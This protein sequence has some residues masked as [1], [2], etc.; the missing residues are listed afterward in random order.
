VRSDEL[1][2]ELP[3]TADSVT[4][5]RKAA[6]DR[7][8]RAAEAHLVAA[9]YSV[10]ERNLRVGRDEIDLLVQSGDVVAIV[11]V[12]TRGATAYQGP[13]ASVDGKKRSKMVRAAERL[14]QTRWSKDPHALRFDVVGVSFDEGGVHVEH[15]TGAFT[16]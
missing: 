11:E 4:T 12:R 15:I 13:L 5:A 2:H 16:G 1:R 3:A 9:G 10:L 14:W 7:A 8:E 6:G